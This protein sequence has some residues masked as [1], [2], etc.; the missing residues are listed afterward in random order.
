MK[1]PQGP[2][3]VIFD[4]D[5]LLIDTV[6]MYVQAMIVASADVGHPLSQDYLLSLVGLL[7]REL[8]A[9]MVLDL[10]GAFPLVPFARAM[11]TRLEPL[12][13]A[14]VALKPGAKELIDML[15]Q[16]AMPIAV[17]TSMKRPDALHHLDL[18]GL[19][20][21]FGHVVGRDDVGN[22][23]PYPD[24]HLKAASELGVAASAG[25]VLEDS[26]N[27]ARAAHAAGAMT[28]MV[29]DVVAPTPEITALCIGVRDVLRT[30]L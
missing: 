25:L 28:I 6:P 26:L 13:R 20:S 14:G 3:A 27:G 7:G 17:A 30:M 8:E 21:R 4:M 9:R 18:H 2:K 24:L 5:G 29:P 15:T 1:L 16:S 12:L 19:A 11:Q 23:K 22:G 10:G